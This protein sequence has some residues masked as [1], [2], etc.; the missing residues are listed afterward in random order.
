[1]EFRIAPESYFILY[2][3]YID[4]DMN[5]I[6]II[7]C[8]LIMHTNNMT[9]SHNTLLQLFSAFIYN[10][11]LLKLIVFFSVFVECM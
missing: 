10:V 7:D 11:M 5:H 9:N 3:L 1:M 6:L 2:T 8:F 4:I